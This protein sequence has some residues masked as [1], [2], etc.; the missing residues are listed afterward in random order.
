MA[1]S[2]P[3]ANL[4]LVLSVADAQQRRSCAGPARGEGARIENPGEQGRCL[5]EERAP[6]VLVDAILGGFAS[7]KRPVSQTG[8]QKSHPAEIEGRIYPRQL[9]R[10]GLTGLG[11]R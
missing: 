3:S 6:V 10:E 9:L 4:L 5:R 11:G 1:R 8:E 2:A 7:Q